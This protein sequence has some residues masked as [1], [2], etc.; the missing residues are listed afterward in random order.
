MAS[1]FPSNS[2]QDRVGGTGDRQRL[3]S[4]QRPGDPLRARQ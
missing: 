2:E 1:P 3:P 4:W